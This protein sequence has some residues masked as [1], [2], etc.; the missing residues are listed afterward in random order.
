MIK[1]S[2]IKASM[3][4]V[5]SNIKPYIKKKFMASPCIH[6]SDIPV[7]CQ[8]LLSRY[9]NV[10]LQQ[11]LTNNRPDFRIRVKGLF[12]T[13]EK[14]FEVIGDAKKKPEKHNKNDLVWIDRLE[15]MDAALDDF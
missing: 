2:R 11:G 14:S 13:E 4:Q 15:E 6:E 10:E 12:G 5:L 3:P 9:K 8:I 7:I 1:D